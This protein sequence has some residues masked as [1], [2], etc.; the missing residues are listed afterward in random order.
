MNYF[1]SYCRWEWVILEPPPAPEGGESKRTSSEFACNL[2]LLL[3]EGLGVAS[4][5]GGADARTVRPY[6]PAIAFDEE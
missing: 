1:D 4:Y 6:M 2:V 5:F 3:S